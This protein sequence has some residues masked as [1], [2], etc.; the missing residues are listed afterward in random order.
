MTDSTTYST[1]EYSLEKH[2]CQYLFS[3]HLIFFSYPYNS[4]EDALSGLGRN[5]TP[6]IRQL[7]I[8]LLAY[9]SCR[10]GRALELK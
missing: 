8:M 5:A 2:K 3:H 1:V 4:R 7:F 10:K 6:P 9:T